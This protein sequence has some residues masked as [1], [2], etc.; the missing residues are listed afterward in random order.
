MFALA[1]ARATARHIAMCFVQGF[2]RQAGWSETA[3]RENLKFL[4]ADSIR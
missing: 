2:C 3:L 4:A 1:A